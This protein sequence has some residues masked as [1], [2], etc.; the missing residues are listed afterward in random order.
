M[1]RLLVAAM[2]WTHS[3]RTWR[4]L[5]FAPFWVGLLGVLQAHEKT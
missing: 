5:A 4:A 1:M 3:P 2:V